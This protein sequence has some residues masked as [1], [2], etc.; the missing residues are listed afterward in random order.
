MREASRVLKMGLANLSCGYV[1]V[2]CEIPFLSHLRFVYFSICTLHF[3][4][5]VYQKIATQSM[6]V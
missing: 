4:L 5:K 3:H 6:C 2:F 1:G